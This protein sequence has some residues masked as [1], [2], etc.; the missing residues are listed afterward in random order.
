[1]RSHREEPP[2]RNINADD[3]STRPQGSFR[4]ASSATARYSVLSTRY[5]VL[6]TQSGRPRRLSPPHLALAEGH[7]NPDRRQA[8]DSRD[9]AWAGVT[10]ELTNVADSQAGDWERER[11]NLEANS[12]RCAA[13][14]V[15]SAVFPRERPSNGA[16][17]PPPF[18]LAIAVSRE[19]SDAD[20]QINCD[21]RMSVG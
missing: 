19:T 12:G 10:N 6:S 15:E 20:E 18:Q 7:V 4:V 5:S 13:Q 17:P 3:N 11:A 9:S 14:T 8:L 16:V 21:Q 1:L 2:E